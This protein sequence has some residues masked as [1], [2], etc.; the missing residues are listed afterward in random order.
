M[1]SGDFGANGVY[2][3]IWILT[4]NL[5]IA[6]KLLT[7]PGEWNTK[8]IKSVRWFLME[9]G[10]KLVSH[11]RR[12]ILKIATGLDKFRIYLEMRRRAFELLWG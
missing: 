1:P 12:M 3:G 11:G 4:Y 6:Q 9:V 10:G 2:F 8:T 5:F 7:M